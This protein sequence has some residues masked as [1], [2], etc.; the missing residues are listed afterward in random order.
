MMT[1]NC[2]ICSKENSD[3]QEFCSLC[4]TLL[5][6]SAEPAKELS[7]EDV[8]AM[9]ARST[10]VEPQTETAVETPP[11]EPPKALIPETDARPAQPAGML[12]VGRLPE[13]AIETE[14]RP[15]QPPEPLP[16]E[17]PT[18]LAVETSPIEKPTP[19]ASETPPA[20]LP[21]PKPTSRRWSPRC[22]GLGCL[23]V[24]LLV[25]VGVPLLYFFVIRTPI[26]NALLQQIEDRVAQT[27][28][29]AI[30]SGETQT[31]SISQNKANTLV[32]PLWDDKFGLKGGQIA[33]Q[34]DAVVVQATWLSLPVEIRADLRVNDDGGL[35]V[36]SV[37][38]NWVARL[39]FTPASLS[40]AITQYVNDEILRP[41][42]FFLLAFQVTEG[43]LFLA[44]RSR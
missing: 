41:K 11:V 12:P 19:L 36:K 21:P 7:P 40:M 20:P 44:Y 23:G 3:S 27:F 5:R 37:N 18:P 29:I 13:L 8:D 1:I 6:A 38:L 31:A 39:I 10:P 2:P 14:A 42:N 22:L 24:L 4:G 34:Q 25:F 28:T 35:I 15:L 30:Y 43:D 33:F 9:L 16:V 32:T 17:K 26:E